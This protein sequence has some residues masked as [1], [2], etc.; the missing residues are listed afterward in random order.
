MIRSHNEV[1]TLALKAA[2]GAGA[3]LGHA[4]DFAAAVG[5]LAATTPDQIGAVSCALKSPV[6]RP[7]PV[8]EGTRMRLSPVHVIMAGPLLA[9][10]FLTGLA[11]ATLVA[12]DAPALLA[13]YLS[14]IAQ[15][16]H[17]VLD[18]QGDSVIL[19]RV[20]TPTAAP[21]MRP[22]PLD[23]A[24]TDWAFWESLAA[25]TYVPASAASRLAGA[26]AGLTDND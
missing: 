24:D 22:G 8:F 14:G 4:E 21:T 12:V 25:R 9:D 5:V 7:Q 26:G 10:A 18:M 13:A 1:V 6:A 17:V 23:I 3:P 11:Q 19:T 16:C 20:D 2:R 15:H